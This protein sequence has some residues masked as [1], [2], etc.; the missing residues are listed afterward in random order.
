MEA[1]FDQS[2]STYDK[3]FTN[4]C[5]GRK[6]RNHVWEYLSKHLNETDKKL[7]ILELN[8]GT[9][10]DAIWMAGHGHNIVA[11]DISVKMLEASNKKIVMAGLDKQVMTKQLDLTKAKNFKSEQKF[12][13]VFSNFG[14]LNCL[15][16][17]EL[18]SLSSTIKTWLKKDAKLIFVVMP[19]FTQLDSWYRL[20]KFQWA[21]RKERRSGFT[22]VKLNDSHVSCYYHNLEEIKSAFQDFKLEEYNTVG[23]LPSYF[24]SFIEKHPR[25]YKFLLQYENKKLKDNKQVN[26]SDHFLITLSH[27]S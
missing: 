12:D 10:E 16:F 24:E 11:T 26:K 3:A 7:D 20:I 8:C 15:S 14:G 22:E 13:L 5:I 1:S 23:F 19:K 18:K 27:V 21:S 4:T 2:A 25:L 6:Q 9:G 17:D